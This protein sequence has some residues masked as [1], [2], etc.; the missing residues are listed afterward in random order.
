[1]NFRHIKMIGSTA[2]VVFTVLYYLFVISVAIVRLPPLAL[3]WHILFYF[4]SV[5]I[6]FIPAA[7]IVSWIGRE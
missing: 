6:W 4:V 2:L 3:P 5:V 1:M 7:V